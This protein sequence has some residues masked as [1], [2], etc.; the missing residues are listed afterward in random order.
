MTRFGGASAALVAVA[1]MA[2]VLAGCG[3][4]GASTT[5]G[6]ATSRMGQSA[7]EAKVTPVALHLNE[8]SYSVSAPGTTIS[9]TVST[10]AS[11]TVNGHAVAVSAG[12][13]QDKLGLR[14]GNNPVAVEATLGTRAP[15]KTVIH[16]IRHH[17]AAERE[18]LAR[19]RALRAE[20][21]HRHEAEAR[22]RKERELQEQ[23]EHHQQAACPNGTYENSAGNIVCKPY[24]SPTQPAGATAQCEDG[25][26]SFSES[27]SGTCSHHGGVARWLNE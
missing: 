26:Y 22:E 14:I 9:G 23:R 13:W 27:R 24:E 1:A 20:T 19:A 2:G 5:G 12:R 7:A 15:A 10:G 25:T 17:S 6:N 3:S 21:K 4:N 11:V 16:V 18:A 8:G